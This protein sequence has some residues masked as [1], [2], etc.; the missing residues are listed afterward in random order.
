MVAKNAKGDTI[1]VNAK[2][3]ILA[4]GGYNFNVDMVKKLTGIDMIPVSAPG[5][6]GDGIKMAMDVGAIGDKH[7]A[8]D[9]QRRIHAS[10]GRGHLQR[11]E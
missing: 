4:T 5:R 7:G 9:D 11:C 8:D 2:N 10:R 3:V 1:T 6:T